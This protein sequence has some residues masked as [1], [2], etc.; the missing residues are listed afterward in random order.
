MARKKE[1]N[2]EE[3]LDKAMNL[4]WRNGYE[5]TSMQML[6]K[7]MGINKFSIYSSFDSKIGLLA[8]SIKLYQKKLNVLLNKLKLSSNGLEGIKQYFYDFVE[9]TKDREFGKG[10]L[11]T[12]TMNEL[13]SSGNE[14]LIKLSQNFASEINQAF[15]NNLRQD[16]SKNKELLEQQLDFLILSLMGLTFA[17]RMF[18]KKQIVHYIEQIFDKIQE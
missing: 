6:E 13:G 18:S 11:V 14:Q 1:Y 3:V 2:E 17:T 16:G 15:Y 10:C 9:F 4:F 5:R 7:E 8:E 12:S